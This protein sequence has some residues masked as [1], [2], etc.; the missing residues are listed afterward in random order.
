[1]DWGKQ[2]VPCIVDSCL[3][4]GTAP[5]TRY[6]A[7]RWCVLGDFQ[8]EMKLRGCT[9]WLEGLKLGGVTCSD[10]GYRG[11]K[12]AQYW[13][14]SVWFLSYWALLH[15]RKHNQCIMIENKYHG[16]CMVLARWYGTAVTVAQECH[17]KISRPDFSRQILCLVEGYAAECGQ[18]ILPYIHPNSALCF[19]R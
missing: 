14:S 18:K 10:F 9:K 16:T 6:R 4:D 1:M 7:D 2:R 19:N 13:M 8:T 5:K 11:G 15:V 12:L 3:F 17:S